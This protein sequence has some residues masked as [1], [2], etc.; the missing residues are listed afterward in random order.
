V[1]DEFELHAKD[2]ELASATNVPAFTPSHLLS[3]W[4]IDGAVLKRCGKKLCFVLQTAFFCIRSGSKNRVC[5]GILATL[6][7]LFLIALPQTQGCPGTTT[8]RLVL[9]DSVYAD[10]GSSVLDRKPL[11][12]MQRV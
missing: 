6:R 7:R 8:E 2:E 4:R 10:S 1:S 5:F 9:C 12:K 3:E 11:V